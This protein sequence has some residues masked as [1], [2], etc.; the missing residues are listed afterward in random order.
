MKTVIRRLPEEISSRIAAGEVVERPSSVVK[1]LL[2][3]ALDA[4]STRV[5]VSLRQG[6][7]S[8]LVVEDD[9]RGIPYDELE[10]AVERYATSKLEALEDLESIASLGFRGEALASIGTVSRMEVRSREGDAAGGV[11]RVRE[12]ETEPKSRIHCPPGTRVQ[13]DDIFCNL[14]AR[15]KFLKSASAEY[16]R[17]LTLVQSYALA[18][19]S[20]AFFLENEGKQTFSSRGD[21][22][23]KAL[24]ERMWGTE[25]PLRSHDLSLDGTRVSLVWQ[26]T[27]GS[28]RTRLEAFVNGRRIQD[29]MIRAAL[30]ATGAD[31]SGQWLVLIDVPPLEVDVNIHPAKAEVRFRYGNRVFDALRRAASGLL[32]APRSL[33]LGRSS[34][35]PALPMRSLSGRLPGLGGAFPEPSGPSRSSRPEPACEKKGSSPSSGGFRDGAYAA[36]RAETAD[37]FCRVASPEGPREETPGVAS[38]EMPVPDPVS[39]EWGLPRYMG[40]MSAG[41]LLFEWEGS[42]VIMDPHAAHE[43]VQYEEIC[44]RVRGQV[45]TQN[46]TFPFSLPPSLSQ[47]ART[48]LEDLKKLGF[49]FD[50]QDGELRVTGVPDLFR[51]RPPLAGDLVRT[52]LD[53]LDE[54][55]GEPMDLGLWRRWATLACKRSVK[56]GERMDRTEA[57]AL[58][59]AL[60]RCESPHSCPHGRPVVLAIESGQ[61]ARHFGRE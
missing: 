12:G 42:L 6:G 20:V 3:N 54:E 5:V 7:K 57:L 4:G 25:P 47:R 50:E 10:L 1:E 35:S 16:R 2:E 22:N 38:P 45:Q 37:F 40:Q 24:V 43:R 30:N 52:A 60:G 56:L 19:P 14:P 26:P 58:W 29:G 61:L 32:D 48:L 49:L 15:R 27:P 59:Q 8:S 23:R 53:A 39:D 31:I 13:V 9:G 41:Y 36:G 33:K 51:R 21:G 11:I 46:L 44:D 17:V 18:Y 55:G 34:E 28:R